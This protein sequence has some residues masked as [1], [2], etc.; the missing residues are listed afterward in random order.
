MR[1]W[2]RAA[3]LAAQ[4]QRLIREA[5]RLVGLPLLIRQLAQTEALHGVA[6]MAAGAAHELN[7]PLSVISG[8]VLHSLSDGGT[9]TDSIWYN[10]KWVTSDATRS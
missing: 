9:I 2:S 5:Q 8:I 1:I 4:T 6:E 10:E 7:N 3:D